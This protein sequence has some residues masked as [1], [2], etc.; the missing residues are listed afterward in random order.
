VRCWVGGIDYKWFKYDHVTA[1]RQVGSTIKPLIYSLAVQDA[2]YTPSTEIPGGPVQYGGEMR[3]FHGG[4]GTMAN[5][6]AWSKNTASIRITNLVGV[7]RVIEFAQ[8]CGVKAKLPP[9]SSLA[10]GAAEIPM[11]EMLQAYTMFPNKSLNTA[12]ILYTRIEDKNGNILEEFKPERKQVMSESSA[13][14]MVQLMQGVVQFGTARSL[15]GYNIPVEKAGKTGTTNDNTDGWFIGYTPELLAG[16]WV[17]CEDPFIRIYSGTSGGNEMAAPKWGIFMSKVYADRK[18]NYGQIKTFEKP[19]SMGSGELSA[20]QD[21]SKIFSQGDST[22]DEG[23]GNANDFIVDP[24]AADMTPQENIG[25][26]SEIPKTPADTGKS[27]NKPDPKITM[28]AA[29]PADPKAKQPIPAKGKTG[30]EKNDY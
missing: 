12:P 1:K 6:L 20:D 17:G 4:G 13:F 29:K 22:M 2:G 5:C 9:Y 15:N 23:N 25:I 10:L 24:S 19:A 8:S 7:K 27:K 18:L 30:G 21:W 26:E 14:T 11:L 3:T 16:T 28:P